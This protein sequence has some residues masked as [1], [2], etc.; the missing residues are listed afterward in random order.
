MLSDYLQSS[1][2]D[3]MKQFIDGVPEDC[4]IEITV[5]SKQRIRK[6][7]QTHIYID[8]KLTYDFDFVTKKYLNLSRDSEFYMTDAEA[9][10]LNL[11]LISGVFNPVVPHW[12]PYAERNIARHDNPLKE[13]KDALAENKKVVITY[14]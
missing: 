4:T 1:D 14:D 2:K 3:L 11:Y 7:A 9:S 12:W 10:A 6:S 8:D 5:H 13:L